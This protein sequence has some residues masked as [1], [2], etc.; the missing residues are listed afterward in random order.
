MPRTLQR[1][2]RAMAGTSA[3]LLGVALCLTFAYPT[4]AA[5]PRKTTPQRT[6][7][8]LSA[9]EVVE[10]HVSAR[11]GLSIHRGYARASDRVLWAVIRFLS[12]STRPA[13]RRAARQEILS[14]RAE[15]HAGGTPRPRRA[16]DRP[17]PGDVAHTER[18]ARTFREANAA[19][20]GGALVPRS[21]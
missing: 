4:A 10:R 17:L 19:H 7:P 1:G 3:L 15:L 20:F 6:T 16:P 21:R 8:R 12:R 14:F 9:T 11:G 5:E 13:L 18:L 2:V